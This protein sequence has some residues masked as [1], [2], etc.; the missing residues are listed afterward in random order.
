MDD[1]LKEYIVDSGIV[2]GITQYSQ[3]QSK[4]FGIHYQQ[5]KKRQ[6][7]SRQKQSMPT[8]IVTVLNFGFLVFWLLGFYPVLLLVILT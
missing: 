2:N 4:R 5:Q 6:T 3:L 8:K 1:E 7:R